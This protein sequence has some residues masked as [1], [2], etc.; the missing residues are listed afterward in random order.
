VAACGGDDGRAS[1]PTSA[2]GVA[3]GGPIPTSDGD[4]G[5]GTSAP[6]GGS[7]GSGDTG[8]APP[9]FAC[10]APA[11]SS[12]ILAGLVLF[13]PAQPHPGDTLT[14][15][16]RAT[17]G[18]GHGD[19]PPMQ[20][21]AETADGTDVHDPTMRAGGEALYY[22][23]L[24]DVPLG[25]V[26]ITGLIDGAPEVAAKVTVTPR[27]P[28]PPVDGGIFKVTSNHQWTCEAQPGFGNELHVWVRE[29]DG[30]PIEG[31]DVAITLPDSTDLDS[32]YNAD[33]RGLPTTMTTGADGHAMVFNS[34][35]ISDNGILPLQ[36]AVAGVASDLATELTTGWWEATDDGCN[37]CNLATINVWGH[38]SY[39]VEFVREP[40]ATE[41]CVVEND[42]AGMA[43]C[44]PPGHI[45]HHPSVRACWPAR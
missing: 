31:I 15:V 42:H 45:H 44:G 40:A 3:T 24:P 41:I 5:D 1:T 20:L 16:V 26:C 12:D 8:P 18:L 13:D 28:S 25:D 2:S 22:Y 35:P 7:D 14:V 34:W 37:Y 27:P 9:P 43:A 10:E 17:N 30:T 11:A 21:S 36:V 23:A 32:I 19:A 33:A 4:D 29:A 38:W 6:T 39:T